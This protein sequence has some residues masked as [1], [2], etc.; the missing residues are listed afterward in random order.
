MNHTDDA[1][2]VSSCDSNCSQTDRHTELSNLI[3]L[4][5]LDAMM[6]TLSNPPKTPDNAMLA[7]F[8]PPPWISKTNLLYNDRSLWSHPS[9]ILCA[10]MV[11]IFEKAKEE[12]MEKTDRKVLLVQFIKLYFAWCKDVKARRSKG[13]PKVASMAIAP[14]LVDS[15]SYCRVCPVDVHCGE[16]CKS[17][18]EFQKAQ[19]FNESKSNNLVSSTDFHL[20]FKSIQRLNDSADVYNKNIGFVG[21]LLF[22]H[23]HDSLVQRVISRTGLILEEGLTLCK[24][25]VISYVPSKYLS[26]EQVQKIV[27]EKNDQYEEDWEEAG[28]LFYILPLFGTYQSSYLPQYC[29][30]I[31]NEQSPVDLALLKLDGIIG[32]TYI[33]LKNRLNQTR[34]LIESV[35]RIIFSV[36]KIAGS[37]EV[38]STPSLS[39]SHM[40]SYTSNDIVDVREID[41]DTNSLNCITSHGDSVQK[42]LSELRRL[43]SIMRLYCSSQEFST[44]LSKLNAVSISRHIV[45]TSDDDIFCASRGRAWK[46]HFEVSSTASKRRKLYDKPNS[47]TA[48]DTNTSSWYLKNLFV[49]DAVGVVQEGKCQLFY[50]DFVFWDRN[51]FNRAWTKQ[52]MERMKEMNKKMAAQQLQSP[53][54]LV[55][56]TKIVVLQ[57]RTKTSIRPNDVMDQDYYREDDKEQNTNENEKYPGLGW[58]FELI[59]WPDEILRI[60]RVANSSPAHCAGLKPNDKIL[61]IDGT[62][63]CMIRTKT[64]LANRL[65]GCNLSKE[66]L[67]EENIAPMPYLYQEQCGGMVKDILVLEIQKDTK[68]EVA[69]SFHSRERTSVA[70]NLN[71]SV[72]PVQHRLLI[73]AT[74]ESLTHSKKNKM[75]E[76]HQ[77]KTIQC[78]NAPQQPINHLPDSIEN[79][80]TM[81][82]LYT[83]GVN[84]CFFTMAECAVL[85]EAMRRNCPKLSVR[86][87]TPRYDPFRVDEEYRARII[88]YIERNSLSCIPRLSETQW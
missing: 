9:R 42:S 75:S 76:L 85:I 52:R 22:V 83:P 87:L 30:Y 13:P 5:R 35:D 34:K 39:Y 77:Q 21:S 23:Q 12:K 67:V 20:D 59:L 69:N 48:S 62:P 3:S 60:G 58:G 86:L 46:N 51:V 74:E 50:T 66:S 53:S 11:F 84:S 2:S 7:P 88:P 47:K 31:E 25:L 8:K 40:K 49:F 33:Q 45:G 32:M 56:R 38:E 78:S 65:L 29:K 54:N 64:D 27:L 17:C 82:H 28:G 43:C 44:V 6:D 73:T 4:R 55:D 14:W 10:G 26:S 24:L 63:S 79:I 72:Q 71:Q 1:I 37:K 68:T 81:E 57:K 19:Y 16:F 70:N 80:L 18:F 15:C 41:V 61:S 36:G